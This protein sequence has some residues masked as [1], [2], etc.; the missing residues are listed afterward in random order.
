MA[1]KMSEDD[2]PEAAKYCDWYMAEALPHLREYVTHVR[3]CP[4]CRSAL[5]SIKDKLGFDLL[6]ASDEEAMAMLAQL[7]QEYIEGV[8]K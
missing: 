3:N 5:S 7:P 6:K 8:D 2:C 4:M 1:E